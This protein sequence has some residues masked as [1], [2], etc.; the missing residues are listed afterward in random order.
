M[1]PIRYRLLIDSYRKVSYYLGSM[2]LVLA[3][4]LC[5]P[6]IYLMFDPSE[7]K[8]ASAFLYPVLLSI[9]GWLLFGK[10]VG[11]KGSNAMSYEEACVTVT[12]SWIV[13]CLISAIPLILL[14]RMSF[15]NSYFEAMSGYTTTGLTLIDY[16]KTSNLIYLWRSVMQFA[17]G[18]GIAVLLISLANAPFGSSLSSAEGKTDLLVPQIQRSTRLVMIIY[19]SYAIA[20]IMAL[21]LAGVD[22][23]NSVIHALSA[24]S[25][26]GFSTHPESISVFHSVT[27]EAMI[28]VMMI[29]GNLNF[30][31]AYILFGGKVKAFLMNGEVKVQFILVPLSAALIVMLFAANLYGS[32]SQSIRISLFETVSALT[33]TGYTT[34]SY[35]NWPEYGL[36]ILILLMLT[37]GGTNSTAGGIKQYR[38][39]LIYKHILQTLKQ[40]TSPKTRTVRLSYWWGEKKQY[41]TNSLVNSLFLFLVLYFMIYIIGI[42]VM[43]AYGYSLK[44]SCFEFASALSN[45]GL[46]IGA[47][48]SE[49]PNLLTWIFTISML[50]GRLEI[51]IILV[52]IAKIFRDGKRIFI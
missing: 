11:K 31:N 25:T 41:L 14:N 44:E 27:V 36:L 43:S 32:I 46:S 49:M 37:G 17:G 6:L 7:T 1:L 38:F 19:V 33:T 2:L 47:T 50:L 13:I 21:K 28:L 15:S 51:L 29:L 24:L 9:S 40:I 10:I 16:T 26:G 42:C 4:L 20:G 23:F 3:G 8:L 35:S 52:A 12:L 39:Y 30:L 18:A 48:S 22:W 5:A 45:S 34:T